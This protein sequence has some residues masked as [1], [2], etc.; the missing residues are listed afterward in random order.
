ME[1]N[2]NS[3]TEKTKE[4][5]KKEKDKKSSDAKKRNKREMRLINFQRLMVNIVV[6]LVILWALFY[7][8]IGV[9]HAPNSDMNPKI[10]SGD[11]IV[12]YKL[13]KT[14]SSGDVVIVN[15]N[16]VKYAARVI[17]RGG[18]TVEILEKGGV[19]V[20]GNSLVESSIYEK[21]YPYRF[22]KSPLTLKSDEY[23]VMV[24]AREHGED[25]RFFGPVKK[26]DIDGLIVG[27]YRRTGF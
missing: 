15:K 14:P 21:T 27:I 8:V 20:N 18:D 25:S 26:S 17:A 12:Y 24:D 22:V 9:M 19:R 23:F 5:E 10:Q 16:N 1:K 11:L 6:I 13:N 7:F 3:Q 4:Q 2:N